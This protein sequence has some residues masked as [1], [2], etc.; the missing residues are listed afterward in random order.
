MATNRTISY[1]IELCVCALLEKGLYEEGLLR[2]GCT[3]TKLKRMRSAIDAHVIGPHLPREY[4]DVHV[5]AGVLKSYLR[6]LPDPLLTFRLY[7]EFVA[8]AQR[9]TEA[10]R[11]SAILNAINQLPEGHYYNLRYLTKFLSCLAQK[12]AHNKM[13]P[14]E[15][16]LMATNRTISYVIELC[17][18]ALL[19]KG[20]YEEG[21]LRVGCTNTKLKRMRSAIDAHVIG[22]HLPREYQDVHVIAGVLKSY[23]RDLPDPLLTFRLYNEFVA[24]AQ[25]PTEAQRKSAILNAINQLPEGHYYNLRYLT[26]FLSCLAQKNAHNKMSSQNIAIVM[27]PNLL[28][29]RESDDTDYAQNMNS[30]AA[31]N[32]I[33]ELLV[34]DWNFFFD[35]DFDF[36]LTMSKDDLFPENSGASGDREPPGF[37]SFK[38]RVEEIVVNAVFSGMDSMSKSMNA[39]SLAA[40][41]ATA[42]ANNVGGSTGHYQSHSRSSSHD[43]SLILLGD[44]V[45]RSQSNSSL[46]DQS[47]PPQGSPKLPMR[48]RH[49]KPRAP[50]PPDMRGERPRTEKVSEESNNHQRSRKETSS[51]T[52]P[53]AVKS[54]ERGSVENLAKPEKPPRPVMSA[55]CQTLNRM[56]YKCAKAGTVTGVTPQK[57]V[58]LPRTSVAPKNGSTEGARSKSSDEDDVVIRP[59][60]QGEKPAIPERPAT[61]MRPISYKGSLQ[62]VNQIPAG[63]PSSV[64][65]VKKAQSFRLSTG[66]TNKDPNTPT[67]LERT[68]IYNV[69]K[70]Q[71]AI[72]D[73]CGDGTNNGRHLKAEK[74]EVEPDLVTP[75]DTAD[76]GA[77]P[78]SPRGDQQKIK[79]PQIPAPPPPSSN[80]RTSIAA[81]DST[82]L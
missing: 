64:G 60:S 48:R 33:V 16:H 61:L 57:P 74:A 52:P 23:L 12:N 42:N 55:E 46:S 81:A 4:Q 41:A 53:S 43:T 18:C 51:Q 9:P 13:V 14:L 67:V 6:D 35:G 27:S 38:L 1:V 22:P 71:V 76:V 45:K 3:N 82:N 20:L 37:D 10:Q 47:S 15:D 36:Y 19:E 24:A 7:N 68:H 65:D 25:R 72:I 32:I 29:A 21:L 39:A 75:T 54:R 66:N 31:V 80:V 26:K 30:T 56:A 44:Q 78:P 62:E 79:R 11:K 69:D 70:Q 63:I 40:A 28:W 50:T 77:V 58:A 73:V 49:N 8:A 59:N 5:I 2:V 34:S 17:V